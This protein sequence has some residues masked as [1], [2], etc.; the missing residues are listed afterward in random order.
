MVLVHLFF[1]FFF[2]VVVV[3]VDVD[4][5]VNVDVNV[6]LCS[7]RTIV[8]QRSA[9]ENERDAT[10]VHFYRGLTILDAAMVRPIVRRQDE[11][12]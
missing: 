6:D 3:V 9:W 12:S 2:N 7:R 8:L 10:R 5:D 4:A 11:A 1:F